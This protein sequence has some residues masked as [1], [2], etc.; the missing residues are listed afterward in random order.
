MFN[1]LAI[2]SN[3]LTYIKLSCSKA[4]FLKLKAVLSQTQAELLEQIN[5]P[6]IN[7]IYGL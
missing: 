3:Y 1:K 7:S 2:L 5:I 6:T 4:C